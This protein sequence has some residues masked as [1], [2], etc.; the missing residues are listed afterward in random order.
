MTESKIARLVD[1]V[2]HQRE[3]LHEVGLLTDDEYAA[4]ASEPGSVERLSSYDEMAAEMANMRLELEQVNALVREFGYGQGEIDAGI[5][6]CLRHIIESLR[7][8]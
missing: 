1:L 2:R 6:D 3:E 5:A 8:P 4:L 7:K